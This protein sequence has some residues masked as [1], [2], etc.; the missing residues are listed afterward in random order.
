MV[1]Y[2]P[3]STSRAHPVQLPLP[4]IHRDLP[5]AEQPYIAVST[6]T[7]DGRLAASSVFERLGWHPGHHLHPTVRGPALILTAAAESSKHRLDR[8]RHFRIPAAI[9]ARIHL[10]TGDRL[11]LIALH[12][13]VL[14]YA[15]GAL[16]EL[17]HL[18]EHSTPD[19]R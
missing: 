13:Q 4:L 12:E 10:D 3:P 14:I 17:L 6:L 2:F 5:G 9:R 1:H 11:L 18:A 7:A 16:Y 15:P 8:H 19:H